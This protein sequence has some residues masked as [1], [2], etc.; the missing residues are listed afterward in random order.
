MDFEV[1]MMTIL[2][3]KVETTNQTSFPPFQFF[4]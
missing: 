3:K 1:L 4:N 2:I